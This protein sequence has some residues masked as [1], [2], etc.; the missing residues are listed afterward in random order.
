MALYYIEQLLRS[1]GT[2]LR[3]WPEM[4]YPDDTYISEFGN[5]LIH[6]ETDY[7]PVELQSEYERLHASLTTEQKGV[8]ETIIQSVESG[9]GGLYFVY[10]YGGTGKTFL[11]KTLSA[12]IRRKGDIVLNVASS[13][14]ASLLMPGGRTAHSRFHIPI[15]V[16]ET[17]TCSISAQSDLGKLL[18]K[19]KLIIWDEAPMANKL[20]FEALDRTLRDILRKT[21]YDTCDE[22]FGNMTMVFGGD[23]RQVLPV[24]PKGSREDIVTASLRKSYLWNSCKVLKLTT[25]MRLTVGSRPEDVNEIRE[26]ADWILKVGDGDLGEPNDGEVSIDVPREILIDVVVDPVQSI[27][28]FTYPNILDNIDDPTYFQ[29]KAILAPTN[30]VVDSI[31][32]HLLDKFPGEEMVFLSCDSVNKTERGSAIDNSIFSPEFINGLKFSGVPNHRLALKVGVPIMLL[33]NIDQANGLCNGTRL[34]VI[35]LSRTSIHASIINGT[36]F[37]KTVI[38]PRLRITPSDKR[39][40]LKIV[41]KQFPIS[42]SFAMTINKSQGQSLSKVGLFLP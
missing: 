35:R 14:I 33:R 17:S 42:L 29:E 2:T 7:N 40:P 16:D 9:T 4:P 39:L 6:D 30:E 20:C 31:N 36:N 3:H 32:G 18:K 1:R 37:G 22:P 24:I 15:N 28:D 41:R 5:R 26:F 19:C 34:Q 13:G 11:W 23:Y 38:I 8:Y 27:I 10:G 21:R 12:G 25:N